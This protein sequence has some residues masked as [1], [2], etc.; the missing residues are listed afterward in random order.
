[1]QTPI[2]LHRCTA[3]RVAALATAMI[4]CILSG[5]PAA[6]ASP[7][8]SPFPDA[9]DGLQSPPR[10]GS[11]AQ[12]AAYHDP[13]D[14]IGAVNRVWVVPSGLQVWGWARDPNSTDPI[15]VWLYVDNQ[16]RRAVEASL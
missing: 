10:C 16:F 8:E 5:A 15:S 13:D 1:M 3:R 2:R 14:P 7:R 9:C 12:S 4:L 6:A 11:A